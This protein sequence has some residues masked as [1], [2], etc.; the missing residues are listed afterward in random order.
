MAA[1]LA[2]R[3]TGKK[4]FWIQGFTNPPAINFLSHLLMTQADRIIVNSR[5][6]ITKLITLGFD[7]AKIKYQR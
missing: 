4:F 2:A 7:K 3:L 1:V 6:E 5:K